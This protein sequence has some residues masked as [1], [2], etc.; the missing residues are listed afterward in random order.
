MTIIY[1]IIFYRIQPRR[2]KFKLR[3]L[4]VTMMIFITRKW[5]TIKYWLIWSSFKISLTDFIFFIHRKLPIHWL[6]SKSLSKWQAYIFSGLSHG[7]F[8]LPCWEVE[9]LIF[10]DSSVQWDGVDVVMVEASWLFWSLHLKNVLIVFNLPTIHISSYNWE[11]IIVLHM[12]YL[13]YS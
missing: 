4:K 3:S 1:S 7:H 10:D 9:A 5:I 2:V 13:P 6:N 8:E 12:C 11:V